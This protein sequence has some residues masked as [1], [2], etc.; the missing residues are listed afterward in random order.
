[1]WQSNLALDNNP[2]TF[3]GL[4]GKV[5][6]R[7]QWFKQAHSQAAFKANCDCCGEAVR[8]LQLAARCGLPM[9]CHRSTA[10]VHAVLLQ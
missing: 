1:M 10:H 4:Q 8:L 5:S 9:D 3:K 6:Q 7:W 2:Q